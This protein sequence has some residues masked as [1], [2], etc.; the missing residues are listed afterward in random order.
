MRQLDPATEPPAL[1]LEC[2]SL[3]IV[4]EFI[5][6]AATHIRILKNKNAHWL[7]N[8][9]NGASQRTAARVMASLLEA[10]P[11]VVV[12]NFQDSSPY[13]ASHQEVDV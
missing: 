2:Q 11:N 13:D 5:L 10:N 8:D 12:P 4:A 1:A 3:P 6:K 9:R 7:I